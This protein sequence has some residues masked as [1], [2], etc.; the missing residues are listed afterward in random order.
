M[1]N[2]YKLL[3]S[4]EQGMSIFQLNQWKEQGIWYPITQYKKES[5]EIEVVTNIFNPDTEEYHI[6][7]TAN[8]D[9]EEIHDWNTFLLENQ[10][11]IYPLLTNILKCFLPGQTS[12]YQFFYTIHPHWVY[13]EE[14]AI[15]S[16]IA[17]ILNTRD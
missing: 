13:T 11:K 4:L 6:Q 9:P 17:K 7:L 15:I 1:I 3:N 2:L 10:W 14:K 12:N 16:V 5:N 8:Y